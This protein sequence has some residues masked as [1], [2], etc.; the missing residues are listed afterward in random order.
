MTI[1][2]WIY[3]RLITSR[4]PLENENIDRTFLLFDKIVRDIECSFTIYFTQ[5]IDLNY[6]KLKVL[7]VVYVKLSTIELFIFYHTLGYQESE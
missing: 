3:Y 7:L 4:T 6:Y 1:V 5:I 2:C